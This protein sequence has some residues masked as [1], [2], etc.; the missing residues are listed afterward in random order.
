MH[1]IRA[2]PVLVVGIRNRHAEPG[3][4]MVGTRDIADGSFQS[5]SD[6]PFCGKDP[7]NSSCRL[8]ECDRSGIYNVPDI[9]R[10]TTDGNTEDVVNAYQRHLVHTW[11]GQFVAGNRRFPDRHHYRSHQY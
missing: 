10:L 9:I 5:G 3:P 4:N 11:H 2:S 6:V 7:P 8:P 1:R